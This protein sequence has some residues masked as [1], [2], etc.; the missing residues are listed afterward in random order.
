MVIF[1]R[2]CHLVPNGSEL[3]W[4]RTV[5]RLSATFGALSDPT[6][7]AAL[8]RLMSGEASVGELAEP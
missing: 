6:L 1:A 8:E 4:C 7:R 5:P 3:N 2:A